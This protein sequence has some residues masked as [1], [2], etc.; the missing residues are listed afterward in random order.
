MLNFR[1]FSLVVIAFLCQ[2]CGGKEQFKEAIIN[3]DVNKV[4]TFL[5]DGFSANEKF[6]RGMTP[7]MYATRGGHI[8]VVKL[9]IKHNG[10]VNLIN[11]SGV[12]AIVFA[13]GTRN[14]K[15][16]K[17]LIRNGVSVKQKIKGK[18][19]SVSLLY[20]VIS[21]CSLNSLKILMNN[22]ADVNI[23]IRYGNSILTQLL[24]GKNSEERILK[25]EY[26]LKNG[27]DPNITDAL[28]NTVL[29]YAIDDEYKEA[30][31]CLRK[32]GAKTKKELSEQS[33]AEPEFRH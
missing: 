29:D 6:E 21:S 15:M 27:A 9:L 24:E 2:G 11:D 20:L 14:D 19:V 18:E 28:G 22:G 12:P 26:L 31:D 30:V 5:N 13:I 23:R 10:D 4:E 8:D 3:G 17:F 33:G 1:F 16:L 7:I 32:Y 25:L